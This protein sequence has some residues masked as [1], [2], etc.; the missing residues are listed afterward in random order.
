MKI[1]RILFSFGLLCGL[2]SFAFCQQDPQFSQYMFNGLVVNPAYAGSRDAL[3]LNGLFRAQWVGIDGAPVTQTL[4]MHLPS[5]NLKHGFGVTVVNDAISYLGQSW[6]SGDYAFRVPVGKTG[7]LCLG[8]RATGYNYRINWTK[9]DLKNQSDN[10]PVTYGRNFFLPNAGAG[11]YYYSE[12][13]Y[14]GISVPHLLITSLD[15]NRPTIKLSDKSTDIPMFRRHYFAVAGYVFK[16]TE[17]VK[18]KPS[19]LFKY[20]YGVTPEVD[21]NLNFYFVNK[22]GIGASYR[23]LDGIVGMAEFWA[24]PQL[25]IGY[26]YDYPF[27]KLGGFTSG[28]HEIMLSFDFRYGENNVVSPRV[29]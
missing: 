12:K 18:M 20:V 21:I 5:R 26:A 1:I 27:T 24:T 6:V 4:S 7:K 25:R 8:I 13:A 3:H 14:I 15:Q 28:S 29:F 22:F 10:V 19:F 16:L 2:W 23:S 11:I 17:F 9:A